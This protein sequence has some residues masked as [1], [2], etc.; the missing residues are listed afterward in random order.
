MANLADVIFDIIDQ[1]PIGTDF[2]GGIRAGNFATSGSATTVGVGVGTTQA[3]SFKVDISQENIITATLN[4]AGYVPLSTLLPDILSASK[5]GNAIKFNL[6]RTIQIV[7]DEEINNLIVSGY[8]QY[9]EKVVC[10][11]APGTL[12][13]PVRPFDRLTSVYIE[14]ANYP[15]EITIS[16]Q[17]GFEIPTT[18]N[19]DELQLIT[20]TSNQGKII[21]QDNGGTPPFMPYYSKLNIVNP[22]PNTPQTLTAGVS[23]TVV[24]CEETLPILTYWFLTTNYGWDFGNTSEIAYPN[25]LNK[26][27]GEPP[28]SVGWTDWKG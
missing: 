6:P 25:D 19:G 28:Y 14:A 21:D 5:V 10:G 22:T 26:V 1:Q 18:N 3:Y 27:I 17:F 24:Y 15:A 8:S 9:D 2:R 12:L 7:S 11:A 16:T 4:S 20:A 13:S 23:R